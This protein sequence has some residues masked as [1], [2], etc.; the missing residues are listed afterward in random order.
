MIFFIGVKISQC[1]HN[2]S[3]ACTCI[4]RN[5]VGLSHA[6]TFDNLKMSVSINWCLYVSCARSAAN[7]SL[8]DGRNHMI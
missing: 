1:V 8:L 5:S 3:S 6:E 7:V 2:L 4:S